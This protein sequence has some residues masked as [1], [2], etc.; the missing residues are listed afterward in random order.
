MAIIPAHQTGF[1]DEYLGLKRLE[2]G[3]MRYSTARVVGGQAFPR[4]IEFFT[5]PIGQA[6]QGFARPLTLAETNLL[7]AKRLDKDVEGYVAQVRVSL[8]PIGEAAELPEVQ[9]FLNRVLEDTL[10]EQ[11]IN[12]S[13]VS[14][15][16]PSIMYPAIGTTRG[17]LQMNA[18]TPQGMGSQGTPAKLV[19]QLKGFKIPNGGA[20]SAAMIVNSLAADIATI[21]EG[22]DF[23]AV[24]EWHGEFSKP[25]SI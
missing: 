18:A 4:R 23:L 22:Y 12:R 2:Y 3:A 10:L 6:G 9:S 17:G 16:R 7:T 21:P 25:I 5:T 13:Y 20:F 15:D 8:V 11:R 19:T 1:G 14:G 24:L